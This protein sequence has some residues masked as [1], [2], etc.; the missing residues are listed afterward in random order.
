[1][2]KKPVIIYGA[3]GYTGRLAVE[4]CAGRMNSTSSWPPAKPP[5]GVGWL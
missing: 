4:A 3:S 1:M 5:T 2:S